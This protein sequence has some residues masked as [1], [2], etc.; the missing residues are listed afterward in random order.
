MCVCGRS[1]QGGGGE[2]GGGEASD[3]AYQLGQGG[4]ARQG[5]LGPCARRPG[6]EGHVSTG[7]MAIRCS[8]GAAC[9]RARERTDCGR[10]WETACRHMRDG[11]DQ[12][13]MSERKETSIV[14][15]I[16]VLLLT[17][18]GLLEAC[19]TPK[20]SSHGS[21]TIGLC[22]AVYCL[23]STRVLT[24]VYAR[25]RYACGDRTSVWRCVRSAE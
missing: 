3:G 4:A 19:S 20:S 15:K 6:P 5:D 10:L 2:A 7:W 11:G 24:I 8:G 14:K 17:S 1:R 9:T 25:T 18:T 16:K 13:S 22:A 21:S 12:R 23:L